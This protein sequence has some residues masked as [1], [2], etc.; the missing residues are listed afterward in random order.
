MSAEL[1]RRGIKSDCLVF[2]PHPF[3]YPF[4]FTLSK[5][6]GTAK[7]LIEIRRIYWLFRII[8]RYNT[9]HFHFGSTLAGRVAPNS[10]W[11]FLKRI[12]RFPYTQYLNLFQIFE[13]RLYKLFKMKLFIHYQGDDARQGS[14][15][16]GLNYSLLQVAEKGYYSETS[17]KFKAAQIKRIAAFTE[18]TYYVNPDLGPL[19][20]YESE[21]I[22]YSHIDNSKFTTVPYFP[23]RERIRIV[24]APSNKGLKGTKFIINTLERISTIN[25]KVHIEVIENLP[26]ELA[27]QKYQ[28]A[29]LVID[30]MFAGWYGGLSV[31]ALAFGIPV[32]CYLRKE[33]FTNLNQDMIRELPVINVTIET[34][35]QQILDF[36]TLSDSDIKDLR[37]RCRAFVEKW[38]NVD[39]ICDQIVIHYL[40]AH[41]TN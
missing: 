10:E 37:K 24:H 26:H 8:R 4:D 27:L 12:S 11:S 21:F 41:E 14:Q 31:E 23:N 29:D 35:E 7:F 30:Q 13:L 20:P 18:K 33:D 5:D 36:I 39:S 40:K 38:H 25:P 3:G 9:I 1:R 19:L 17:D 22:P 32:M 2:A 6:D 34:F 15:M 16:Q 28:E